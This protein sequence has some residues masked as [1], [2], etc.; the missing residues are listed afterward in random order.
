MN[1]SSITEVMNIIADTFGCD[2]ATLKPETGP[3]DIP[4]WDSLGHIMILEALNARVGFELPLEE[5]IEAK[6]IASIAML[7]NKR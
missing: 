2:P 6:S 5:A 1:E 3:G 4:Q 7:L